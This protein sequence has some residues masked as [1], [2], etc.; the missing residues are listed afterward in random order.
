MTGH[1]SATNFVFKCKRRSQSDAIIGFINHNLEELKS[2]PADNVKV[3][4][5]SIFRF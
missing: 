5:N 1:K 2:Q 3:N 4:S